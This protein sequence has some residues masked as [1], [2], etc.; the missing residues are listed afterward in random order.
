MEEFHADILLLFLTYREYA[1]DMLNVIY[2]I[3]QYVLNMGQPYCNI[4][5]YVFCHIVSPLFSILLTW[6][7]NILAAFYFLAVIALNLGQSKILSL[8][9][10]L[11]ECMHA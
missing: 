4:L 8:G 6:D 2:S 11:I 1:S 10:E 7:I 3:L 5:Q 9:K